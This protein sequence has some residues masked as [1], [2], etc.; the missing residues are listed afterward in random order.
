MVMRPP[1]RRRKSEVQGSEYLQ[2]GA[3]LMVF[4][5]FKVSISLF[6]LGFSWWFV[7]ATG[8]SRSVYFL[9]FSWCF[10]GLPKVTATIGFEFMSIFRWVFPSFWR[11]GD[12]SSIKQVFPFLRGS[13]HIRSLH[14]TTSG[15]F[16]SS[17]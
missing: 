14:I 9:W 2:V 5:A 1:D 15:S 6:F 8:P 7:L 11:S 10:L 13:L 4:W 3:S 16:G 17:L 12:Q